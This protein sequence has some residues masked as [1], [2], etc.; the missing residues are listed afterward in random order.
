MIPSARSFAVTPFRQPPAHLD[1]HRLWLLLRQA[2]RCQ[3]VLYFR[4]SNAKGQCSKR[5]MRAGVAIPADNCHPRLRQAE[6]RPDH[7]HNPLLRRVH[8]E[9]PHTEFLAVGLQHRDLL[10]RN[11]IRDWSAPRLGRNIVVH[12]GH[13]PRRLPDFSSSNSQP[14]ESLW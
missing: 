10:S 3:N 6:F 2:L 14:V 5:A 8:I 11:K 12:G 13:S 1:L 4:R 9:Q 7:M